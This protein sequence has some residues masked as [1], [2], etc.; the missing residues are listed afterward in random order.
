MTALRIDCVT[1]GSS[2]YGPLRGWC[3]PRFADQESK[4]QTVRWCSGEAL[5]WDISQKS[6]AYVGRGLWPLWLEGSCCSG[7]VGIERWFGARSGSGGEGLVWTKLCSNPGA[8]S[9]SAARPRPIG[10]LVEPEWG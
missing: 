9:D 3:H 1:P 7:F 4:A 8:P 2:H 6:Q 10:A 5:G